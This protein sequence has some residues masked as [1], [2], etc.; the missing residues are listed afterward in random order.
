M[1]IVRLGEGVSDIRGSTGGV[2]YSRNR[3]GPI[4]RARVNPVNPNSPA[5]VAS[6]AIFNQLATYWRDT[7]AA[8][9][10][11][12]WDQYAN[13]TD[14]QNAVGT[15][16]NLTGLNHFVRSN[17]FRIVAGKAPLAA[18]PTEYGLPA[19]EDLWTPAVDSVTG[20]VTIAYTFLADVDEQDYFFYAGSP[21][22]G[23]RV[24][25]NGP[26]RHV[27]TVHGDSIA[28]PASPS[29]SAHPYPLAPGQQAFVYCRRLDTDGRLTEPFRRSC[30]VT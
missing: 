9:Q 12:G 16:I 5:Q 23:S 20:N 17:R 2:V 8:A 13:N 6:R 30:T 1:A 7:L 19:Q 11:A 14:W 10:R 21:V 26:W 28:P 15:T 25:F 27:A 29:I 3:F 18:F 4:T 22:S 24:Y